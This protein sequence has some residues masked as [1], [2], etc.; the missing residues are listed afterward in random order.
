[1]PSK[2]KA[3]YDIQRELDKKYNT[4]LAAA[5]TRSVNTGSGLK[6]GS[7][8]NNKGGIYTGAWVLV[9][10]CETTT[11]SATS[12]GVWSAKTALSTLSATTTY[13]KV[14]TNAIHV[15]AG[16]SA[17][18]GDGAVF[19][20]TSGYELDLSQMN[21]LGFWIYTDDNINV[22]DADGDVYV[23]MYEGTTKV[24]EYIVP[25]YVAA[26]PHGKLFGAA[27]TEW[28]LECPITSDEVQTGYDVSRVT[29]IEVLKMT[30]AMNN[31]KYYAIDYVEA[32][33]ISAGGFPFKQ[34]IILPYADSGS[35]IT[36]GQWVEL[37]S[38][39][40]Q[41]VKT[42]STDNCVLCMGKACNTADASGTVY[43]LTYGLSV[44][45]ADEASMCSAGDGIGLSDISDNLCDDTGAG[46]IQGQ[47]VAK[48]MEGSGSDLDM[49]IV[50][51]Q[52]MSGT[53]GA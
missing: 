3:G 45:I 15:T 47:F 29:S 42:A 9:S 48:A 32:Y 2:I 40:T 1:M 35:G 5:G 22:F 12:R 41:T 20:C 6:K 26:T 10:D 43:V 37:A 23:R 4:A 18:T 52:P 36:R 46:T 7:L 27:A 17:A 44:A 39:V 49:T 33:E 11:T 14:G 38:P 25:A 13:N 34:G 19:T 16:A 50:M 30:T 8:V 31:T 53:D 24:Y 21:F 28:Y 51:I